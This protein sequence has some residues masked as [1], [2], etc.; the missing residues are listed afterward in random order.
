VLSPIRDEGL[1]KSSGA[2]YYILTL[3]PRD[4]AGRYCL[5]LNP[6]DVGLPLEPSAVYKANGLYC[7]DSKLL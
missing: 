5:A 1:R 2:L 6:V 3:S 7:F 4:S